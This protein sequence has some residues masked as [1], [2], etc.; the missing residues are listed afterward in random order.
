[1]TDI[2]TWLNIF[3]FYIESTHEVEI[4]HSALLYFKD[5]K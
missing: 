2:A 5:Y 1:M 4:Y 3:Y